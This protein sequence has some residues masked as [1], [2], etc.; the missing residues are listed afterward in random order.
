MSA[1][2][3]VSAAVSLVLSSGALGASIVLAL[4]CPAASADSAAL[5]AQTPPPAGVAERLQAIRASVSALSEARRTDDPAG[6]AQPEPAGEARLVPAWWG[7]G[8]W[9]RWRFGW[10]NGGW[11]WPNWHNWNNWHNAWPNAAGW[12]NGGPPGGAPPPGWNNWGN[13]WHNFWHNS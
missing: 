1:T 3:P 2:N 10:G 7:N 11:G 4:G 13:G 12:G 8:R 6:S 5:L 9:G